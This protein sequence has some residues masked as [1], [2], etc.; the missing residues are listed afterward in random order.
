MTRPDW[1]D[2]LDAL[3]E[4][5]VWIEG[6]DDLEPITKETYINHAKRFVHWTVSDSSQAREDQR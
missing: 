4:Y 2:W 6:R 5:T 3:T 1:Q